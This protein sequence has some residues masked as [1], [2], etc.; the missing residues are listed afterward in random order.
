MS[1]S[2]YIV[3]ENDETYIQLTTQKPNHNTTIESKY[4]AS[5]FIEKEKKKK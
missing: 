2:I 1:Q 4:T 3:L 5:G